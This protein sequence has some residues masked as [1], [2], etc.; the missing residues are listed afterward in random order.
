M[1]QGISKYISL[2]NIVIWIFFMQKELKVL[3]PNFGYAPCPGLMQEF[4]PGFLYQPWFFQL[5]LLQ[6]MP[7]AFYMVY[8]ELILL[9]FYCFTLLSLSI[10][11]S[12]FFRTFLFPEEGLTLNVHFAWC[13][14]AQVGS[15]IY[16][17]TFP[18]LLHEDTYFLY[19]C[20]SNLRTSHVH[21]REIKYVVLS[22]FTEN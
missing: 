10:F 11:K 20:F 17:L 16:F 5:S 7:S 2:T 1:K 9:F 13:L 6:Q 19:L 18:K 15:E 12:I 4:C 14:F 8:F 22:I 3:D 21:N